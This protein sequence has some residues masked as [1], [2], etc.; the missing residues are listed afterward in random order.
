M[1]AAKFS[2]NKADSLT[3]TELLWNIKNETFGYHLSEIWNNL[4]PRDLQGGLVDV[5]SK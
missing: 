4:C 2:G 3:P 5:P 1:A